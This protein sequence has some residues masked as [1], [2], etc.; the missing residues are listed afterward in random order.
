M[1][2][3]EDPL[4][5]PPTSPT[6]A[7]TFSACYLGSLQVLE[8]KLVTRQCVEVVHSCINSLAASLDEQPLVSDKV[9]TLSN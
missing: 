7:P 3:Q 1:Y 8:S 9:G 2:M 4:L 5:S 6:K